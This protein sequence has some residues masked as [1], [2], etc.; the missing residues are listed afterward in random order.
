VTEL[1]YPAA[2]TRLSDVFTPYTAAPAVLVNSIELADGTRVAARAAA[3]AGVPFVALC[4]DLGRVAIEALTSDRLAA[5]AVGR[6]MTRWAAGAYRPS[7]PATTCSS[8]TPGSAR[9]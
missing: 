8:R 4:A 7:A 9:R 5:I 6:A 3:A 2:L 1:A